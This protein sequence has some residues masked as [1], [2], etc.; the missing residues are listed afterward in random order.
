LPYRLGQRP[1]ELDT[2]QPIGETVN[3]RTI[4]FIYLYNV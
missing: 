2:R 1:G 4:W 3:R